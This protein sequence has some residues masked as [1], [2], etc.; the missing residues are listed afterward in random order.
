MRPEVIAQITNAFELA[1]SIP[2]SF[3]FIK[4][5][6]RTNPL[7]YPSKETLEKLYIDKIHTPR[8]ERLRLREWT[9]VKIGR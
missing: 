5:R 8:Y 3:A 7:L 2:A 9:R 4:E 1:N 6:I